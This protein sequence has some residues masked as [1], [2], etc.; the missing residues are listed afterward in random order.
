M[1]D[2][3]V[4]RLNIARRTA[5]DL[6]KL[7]GR[8]TEQPAMAAAMTNA[9][10][11]LDQVRA[12]SQLPELDPREAAAQTAAQLESQVRAARPVDDSERQRRR[13]VRWWWDEDAGMLNLRGRLPDEQG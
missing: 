3:L 13:S 10:L 9:E 5:N 12:A 6:A 1:A 8:L 4:A 7:A 2:W 11:S